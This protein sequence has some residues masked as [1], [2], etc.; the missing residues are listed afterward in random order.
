MSKT[1]ISQLVVGLAGVLI[2]GLAAFA[3]VVRPPQVVITKP[4]PTV[5]EAEAD[6]EPE[7]LLLSQGSV[8]GALN[9][10]AGW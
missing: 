2:A 8:D 3:Q 1:E 9:N 6:D 10:R 5:I 4:I 7:P